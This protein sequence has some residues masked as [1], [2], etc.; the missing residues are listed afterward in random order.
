MT[1]PTRPGGD[2]AHPVHWLQAIEAHNQILRD[3]AAEKGWI[4]I[5]AAAQ[6]PTHPGLDQEKVWIDLVHVMPEGN[7]AKAEMAAVALR[8]HWLSE[9]H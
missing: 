4:L 1:L 6:F 2:G 7:V 8:D 3:L 5:D 9:Q